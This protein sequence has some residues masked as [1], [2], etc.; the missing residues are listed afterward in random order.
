MEL[1]SGLLLSDETNAIVPG[2]YHQKG[3][4]DENL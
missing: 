1:Y 2:I 3:E 4:K